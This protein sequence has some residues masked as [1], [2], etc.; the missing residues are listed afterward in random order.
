MNSDERFFWIGFV[1]FMIIGKTL[2][3]LEPLNHIWPEHFGPPAEKCEPAKREKT[4]PAAGSESNP[5]PALTLQAPAAI[6]SA[7][8]EV[9]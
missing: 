7:V 1:L 2:I 3:A 4:R 6:N 5:A 9:V 8:P